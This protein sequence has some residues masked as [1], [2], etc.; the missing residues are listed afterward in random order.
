MDGKA[1]NVAVLNSAP[2]KYVRPTLTS[3]GTAA[4]KTLGGEGLC[5]E[6]YAEAQNWC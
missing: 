2:R 6:T 1:Q 5:S 3:L 4:A